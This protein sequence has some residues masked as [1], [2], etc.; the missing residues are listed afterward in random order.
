MYFQDVI[1][2]RHVIG[3]YDDIA[4]NSAAV[5]NVQLRHQQKTAFKFSRVIRETRREIIAKGLAL[6]VL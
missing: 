5:V 6:F 2:Y 3:I 1:T 4:V